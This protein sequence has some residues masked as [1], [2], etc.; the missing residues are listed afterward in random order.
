MA[1]LIQKDVARLEVQVPDVSRMQL[2]Q[3]LQDFYPEPNHLLQG[4]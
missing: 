2:S 1:I 3:G 4:Q